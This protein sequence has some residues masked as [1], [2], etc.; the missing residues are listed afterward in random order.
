MTTAKPDRAQK[1]RVMRRWA[2]G[3]LLG[4]LALFLVAAAAVPGARG[5]MRCRPRQRRILMMIFR[6]RINLE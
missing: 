5:R 6:S 3:L 1:L 4:A 2:L